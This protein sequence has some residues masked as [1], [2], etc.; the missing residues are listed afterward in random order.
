MKEFFKKLF[1]LTCKH[2]FY[3][4]DVINLKTDPKCVNCNKTLS[5]LTPQNNENK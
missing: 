1:S 4:Q 5:E 3:I 2:R